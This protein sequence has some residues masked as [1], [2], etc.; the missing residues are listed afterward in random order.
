[1]TDININDKKIQVE[2]WKSKLEEY[3]QKAQECYKAYESAKIDY[4]LINDSIRE[5]EKKLG[6]NS[7]IDETKCTNTTS[8]NLSQKDDI[9]L[10]VIKDHFFVKKK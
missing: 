2:I 10:E 4:D 5:L 8:N 9:V 7:S 3:K 6:S 1:M